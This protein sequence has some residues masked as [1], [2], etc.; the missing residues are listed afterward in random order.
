MR[1]RMG[2]ALVLLLVGLALAA[3][4]LAPYPPELQLDLATLRN[5]APSLEH[6]L[7]TDPYARD[8]LS[9]VLLGARVSLA[10]ALLSVAVAVTV[11]AAVGVA[12]GWLGGATDAVLMRVVDAALAIPRLFVV[13]VILALWDRVTP[14]ALVAIL[15]GTGWFGISRLVRAEVRAVRVRPWI[16]AAR[17]SGAGGLRL[18]ARHV[19]PN[20]AGPVIVVAAMGIGQVVLLEAGL[21][22]L[23]V[24]VPQPTPSWGA[25]IADGQAVLRTAPWV[26]GG[27]GLALVLTVLAFTLLGDGLRERLDPRAP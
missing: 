13:L 1:L 22:Y 16:A 23:G 19:L 3:P 21:A 24:G 9:R 15:G 6:P 26:A 7:G 14:G 11:G 17:A 27:A 5:A 8:L 2:L 12:S 18:V 10:I 25:I 20:V 4:L